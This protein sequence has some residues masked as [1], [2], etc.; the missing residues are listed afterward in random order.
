MLV[1]C[2]EKAPWSRPW[3]ETLLV[4]AQGSISKTDQVT[5]TH[6]LSAEGAGLEPAFSIPGNS[7]LPLLQGKYQVAKMCQIRLIPHCYR[8]MCVCQ[9]VEAQLL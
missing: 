3:Q 1:S 2:S 4:Q 9:T 8:T 7:L 6:Y 5:V